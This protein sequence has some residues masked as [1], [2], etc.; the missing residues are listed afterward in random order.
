[1]TGTARYSR[2]AERDVVGAILN[3]GTLDEHAGRKVLERA[4]RTGL[5]GRDFYHQS[6]G[7]LYDLLVGLQQQRKPLDPL[8]V[9]LEL[10][11]EAQRRMDGLGDYLDLDIDRVRGHLVALATEALTFT[12]VEHKAA[13]V[14]LLAQARATADLRTAA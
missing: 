6:L 11:A 1:M 8:G 10:E 2:D 4:M 13:H 12:N 7:A 9:A 5:T 3:A 14:R